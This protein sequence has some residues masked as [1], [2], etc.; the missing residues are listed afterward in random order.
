MVIALLSVLLLMPVLSEP[1]S[2]DVFFIS[3][4]VQQVGTP[5]VIR[6]LSEISSLTIVHG[7]ERYRLMGEPSSSIAFTPR[8]AGDY[9]IEAFTVSGRVNISFTAIAEVETAAPPRQ[10]RTIVTISG[11]GSVQNTTPVTV[12]VNTSENRTNTTPQISLPPPV[13]DDGL[14]ILEVKTSKK[15][16][17]PSGIL[18]KDKIGNVINLGQF[19]PELSEEHYDMDVIFSSAPVQRIALRDV[20]IEQGLE[21][22]V[23]P[24]ESDGVIIRERAPARMYAIDPSAVNFTNATVTSN[25]TGTQ[26]WKCVEWNFTA[27]TCYGN[28]TYAQ[29]ITPG[30]SY[31]FIINSTDPGFAETFDDNEAIDVG[32]T[33]LNETTLV[34]GFIDGDANNHASFEIWNTNGTQLVDEVDVDT[35]G[36]LTSRVAVEVINRTH[37]VFAVGDGP[38][39]D[40]DFFIY[41]STGT[42]VQGETQVDPNI[43]ANMDVGLCQIGSEF[44]IVWANTADGDADLEIWGNDGAQIRNEWNVDGNIAPALTLQNLVD[45]AEV[46]SSHWIYIRFDDPPNDATLRWVAADGLS[47]GNN[48]DVDTNVGE[49]GQVAVTHLQDDTFAYVYYDSNVDDIFIGI[50]RPNGLTFTTLLGNTQIDANAGTDSRVDIAEINNAS[51]SHFVVAWQDTS[52]GTIKAAVYNQTGSEVTAPFIVTSSPDTT[53]ELIGV[54]GWNSHLNTGLCN[55]TFAIAYTND[56]DDALFSTYHSNGSRWDGVC[57]FTAPVVTLLAPGNNTEVNDNN[58]DFDFSATDNYDAV[59]ATCTL[60]TNSTGSWAPNA[61]ATDVPVATTTNI[62]VLSLADGTYV[63]NV[64]CIDTHANSDFSV[65]N[66]TVHVNNVT[67]S[68]TD[69]VIND[70]SINQSEYILF[71]STITDTFGVDTGLVELLFPNGTRKNYTLTQDGDTFIHTIIETNQSGIYNITLIWANDTFGQVGQNT[72]PG[73]SFEVYTSDPTPFTLLLP[74]SGTVSSNLQPNLS[75]EQTTDD[76]FD[77]YTIILDKSSDFD[78]P[79]FTYDNDPITNTSRVVDFALD[80]NSIYYWRVVAY[81]VFS[82]SRN[83]TADFTYITDTLGPNLTLNLPVNATEYGTGTITFNFTTSDTNQVDNCTLYVNTTGTFDANETNTTITNGGESFITTDF[84]EGHYLWTVNCIDEAGNS[85]TSYETLNRTIIVDLTPPIVTLL[86]P[87]NNTFE[88]ETNNVQFN[89]SANDVMSDVD[90][91]ELI[92]NDV[93]EQTETT[94]SDGVT[95]TFTEFLLNGQYNWTVN[96]TD[97]N[98]NEGTVAFFNI[99]VSVVDADP[100]LITLNDPVDNEHIPQSNVTFNYTPEDAT[101]IDR[102][103][104]YIDGVLNQTCGN[105]VIGEAGATQVGNFTFVYIT[106][107]NTYASVPVVIATPAS[108]NAGAA[109]DNNGFVPVVKDVTTTGFNVSLCSDNGAATC[110]TTTELE[111]VHYVVF[112]VDAIAN[113]DWIAAGTTTGINHNGADNAVSFGKT[114]SGTPHVFTTTNTYNQNTGEMALNAWVEGADTNASHTTVIGC[115]HEGV[116]DTCTG[117]DATETVGWV[118]ITETQI[119]GYQNG[120]ADI[121]NSG[122]T[123]ASFSPNFGDPIV[124]VTQNDDDGGQDPQ[125]PWARNVVSS[126]MDFRYC[127]QDVADDCDTHTGE[128]VYW[129]ALESG[130]LRA[131]VTPACFVNNFVPNFFNATVPEGAHNWS[132][133]CVDNST[134]FN[135]GTSVTNDFTIDLTDPTVMLNAPSDGAL[136]GAS[137]TFNYTG[138]DTNLNNCSLYTNETGSWIAV[139]VNTTPLNGQP[140]V[141][142]RSI[143]D[144]TY[145]W[146]VLCEDQS[147]RGSFDSSNRT[148]IVDTSPPTYTSNTTDPASPAT[149]SSGALYEF[150]ATWIDNVAVDTVL[151]EHNFTGAL[152]NETVALSVSN[153]YNYTISDLAGGTYRYRWYANDTSNNINQ[154]PLH[155]YII[156]KAT[157]SINLLLNNTD[158]NLTII[159]RSSVNITAAL[160]TPSAGYIEIYLNGTLLENASAP[161]TNFTFFAEPG[162]YNVTAVFNETENHTSS[163]ETHWITILDI[164]PPI[165]TQL[166]PENSS[167]VGTNNVVLQYNVSDSISIDNCTLF[168]D[169]LENE[170]DTSVTVGATEEFN[171]Y[172]EDGNYTWRVQCYDV[173]SNFNTSFTLNFTVLKSDSINVDVTT[174]K[175]QYE[176]GDIANITTNTTDIFGTGLQTNVTTDIIYGNTTFKWWNTSWKKRQPLLITNQLASARTDVV[177]FANITGLA[178]NISDCVNEIRLILLNSSNVKNNYTVIPVEALG[179]D[180]DEYCEFRF[181]ANISGGATNDE[182]YHVYYNNSGATDPGY[183]AIS[184]TVTIMTEDFG[185]SSGGDGWFDTTGTNCGANLCT[186][187]SPW[188]NFNACIDGGDYEFCT[189][190]DGADQ[191]HSSTDYALRLQD[192][193]VWAPERGVIFNMTNNNSLCGTSPCDSIRASSDFVGASLDSLSEFCTLITTDDNA[194]TYT[195]LLNCTNANTTTC[196]TNDAT[197]EPV[198]YF[199]IGPYDACTYAGIE[200]NID[201][202]I[203]FN[204]GGR[205]PGNAGDHCMW[206]NFEVVGDKMTN[207]NITTAFQEEEWHIYRNESETDSS[208][209]VL[210]QFPTASEVFGN[211]SAVSEAYRSNFTNGTGWAQ[212]E[213]VT[214]STPPNVTLYAP[215][216]FFESGAGSFNFTYAPYDI[217]LD[218]CTFYLE[219][220]TFDPIVT[221]T[222]PTNGENNTFYE[223]FVNVGVR[224]WNVLCYDTYGNSAFA[225]LNFT[226]NITGPDLKVNETDVTTSGESLVEGVNITLFANITN[227]GNT[228]TNDSII[229]QFFTGG[230]GGDQINGNITI[231][232]LNISQ[233]VVVNVSYIL[234][235]G[236]NEIFV[237]V[238]PMN[239]Q[240]DANLL[241]NNV[242]INLTVEQYQIYYGNVSSGIVLHSGGDNT[243]Y[244]EFGN[245]S[246]V[247]G[248]LLVADTDSAFSIVNLYAL[249]RTEGGSP[250]GNDFTDADTNLNT[251]SFEDSLEEIWGGGT[252]T[253]LS[254]RGVNFTSNFVENVPY[255][256]STNVTAFWTGILW[257]SADDASANDQFDTT[258]EEDLVFVANINVSQAGMFGT[259][260]YEIKVPS[261]LASYKGSEDTV[262]F[263]FEIV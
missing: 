63:W 171:V 134:S 21:I 87:T 155:T 258:D 7:E 93:V 236:V 132:I 138:N 180:D 198:D 172:L 133:T 255:V 152:I 25:A 228:D 192:L 119:V 45:C 131:P 3:S 150:N 211:Y 230:Q 170:T 118:A 18:I 127:E 169:E 62:T 38:E 214:D 241:N 234:L 19:T 139:Q 66:F 196:Y 164:T 37:F 31:D 141:F 13:M 108:Q 43:G 35:T 56:T 215:P 128:L 88:N 157:G 110:D 143:V 248:H 205:A 217:N 222:T 182:M 130:N 83:S 154:T 73:L 117:G 161:I 29:S 243:S 168:I 176:V 89:A 149:Y 240:D 124:M 120:S 204:L 116:V 44:G 77:N 112:D 26:L 100:P 137:I 52:D 78:S 183:A 202:V 140:S 41:D 24:V 231:A 47:R 238:D 263:F 216:D 39:D 208:G 46:N 28:W 200:C 95:F 246:N 86:V 32:L 30:E 187:N 101:G 96:C 177:V 207:A 122:W 103:E 67:P 27:Q 115:V 70:T 162:F 84:A 225:P 191:A 212:F 175:L 233:S 145:I 257:D 135:S 167:F 237:T 5:V 129:G 218:N 91:C 209:F 253:P 33:A 224:E 90:F 64:Q 194:A 58:V 136:V 65:H 262:S 178:G 11:N 71:N 197:P 166:S 232:E 165:I 106:F 94:I 12:Q 249:T 92:I 160:I 15:E 107:N 81:D 250:T 4:N 48:Q 190:D 14:R 42:Q 245:V 219:Q 184:R 210:M 54:T 235:P 98:G 239:T 244:Y 153:I 252:N 186:E 49:T 220:V 1:V 144:G 189:T 125:Y 97:D 251:S 201:D 148:I 69:G 185:D 158:G 227:Q 259:Y 113:Y 109:E 102:C 79:D 121:T 76:T 34:I 188:G 105:Q 254:V 104:L 80:A 213:I 23:E 242:T 247:A 8:E 16:I 173:Q 223:E 2:N 20:V 61:S 40:V 195:L 193:D 82:N 75:W 114:L 206:D 199:E 72:S 260:D 159:E 68:I 9:V 174:N 123:P 163:V 226:I 99:T 203:Q 51:Q 261:R 22:G 17:V 85:V 55:N 60:Y 221:N 74:L 179:G 142:V 36:D 151:L 53:Y 59:L 57:D 10:R 50:R 156:N 229:V 147:G 126:G 6:V 111:D 256:N 181:L 146:N